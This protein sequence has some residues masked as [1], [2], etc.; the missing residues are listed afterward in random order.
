MKK[1]IDGIYV[2]SD[3]DVAEAKRRGFSRLCACKDGLDGH[4]AMLGYR[5]LSAPQGPEYLFA[6]REHWAVMNVV[7]NDDPSMI[8]D[9]MIFQ[10]L[11]F[12]KKERDEGR[13]LLFHCNHGHER[14]PTMA[15]MFMRAIGEMPYTFSGAKRVFHSLYEPFDVRG[16]GMLVKA[17]ELWATLPKFFKG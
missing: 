15:L 4:R 1:I 11:R 10:A 2:G 12:A 3:A 9:S 17:H 7:D 13:T 6:E 14:G 5:E 16:K 8:A